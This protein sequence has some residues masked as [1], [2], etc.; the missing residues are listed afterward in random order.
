MKSNKSVTKNYLILTCRKKENEINLVF[1][2]N[3]NERIV[4]HIRQLNNI[5]SVF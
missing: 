3:Y 5:E 1:Q 2:S 4:A